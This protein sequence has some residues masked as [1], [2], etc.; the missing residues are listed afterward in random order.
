LR[1]LLL[2]RWKPVSMVQ[3]GQALLRG[4]GLARDS[5]LAVSYVT[6]A[7]DAGKCD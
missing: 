3:F 7:A 1:L 2:L 6:R 4:D 5:A